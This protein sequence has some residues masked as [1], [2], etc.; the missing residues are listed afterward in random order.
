MADNKKIQKIDE[1]LGNLH[2]REG[3]L[4]G[5]I[6][7]TEQ[8]INRLDNVKGPVS[9][10]YYDE[11]KGTLSTL[12]GVYETEL[13]RVQGEIGLQN[14][15]REKAVHDKN[16]GE[17]GSSDA[18]HEVKERQGRDAAVEDETEKREAA[19]QVAE[20]V[21]EAANEVLKHN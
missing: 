1:Q 10:P 6:K 4:Q 20:G 3:E 14:L 13:G 11:L 15:E 12:K 8:R 21:G 2:T 7:D 17:L 19:N 16:V 5:S 18:G 9:E